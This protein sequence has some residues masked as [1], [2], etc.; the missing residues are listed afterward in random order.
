MTHIP[1]RLQRAVVPYILVVLTLIAIGTAVTFRV[2]AAR[3][4]DQSA[5][6]DHAIHH[7][8]IQNC[9]RQNEVRRVAKHAIFTLAD[10]QID[11]LQQQIRQSKAIPP[12]FF[13]SIPP[14]AFR[15]LINKQIRQQR[16]TIADL[17][18][19]KVQARDSFAATDCQA[20][21]PAP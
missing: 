4:A 1:P 13:P 20:A 14:V 6:A 18:A 2:Q 17:N 7:A 3:D 9:L 21:N 10:A 8:A 11:A 16:S 15:K 19:I 12:R 5:A